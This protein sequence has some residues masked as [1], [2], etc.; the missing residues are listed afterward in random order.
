M[1]A[2]RFD[3]GDFTASASDM[4]LVM[5]VLLHYLELVATRSIDL[6]DHLPCYQLLCEMCKHVSQ[7]KRGLHDRESSELHAPST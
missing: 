3:K 1:S 5:P 7:A 4:L 2:K 6:G